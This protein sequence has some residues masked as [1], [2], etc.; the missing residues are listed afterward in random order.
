MVTVWI[1]VF[2]FSVILEAASVSLITI[3]FAFGSLA[4][5]LAAVCGGSEGLQ[6]LLFLS[7][8]VFTLLLTRPFIKKLIPKASLEEANKDL[9]IGEK[10]IV[11]QEINSEKQTGRIRIKGIDWPAISV[12]DSIIPVDSSVIIEKKESTIVYVRNVD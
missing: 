2:I 3:W 12:D 10:A 8:S 7:I 1:L 5:L 11:I 9:D 4:A 6:Y